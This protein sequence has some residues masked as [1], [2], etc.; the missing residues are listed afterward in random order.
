MPI[1]SGGQ[2]V[3]SAQGWSVQMDRTQWVLTH[4]YP[5]VLGD[6][7]K[8]SDWPQAFLPQPYAGDGVC[9]CSRGEN[10]SNSAG[11]CLPTCGNGV[12]DLGETSLNCPGDLRLFPGDA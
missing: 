9:E 7:G 1:A 6:K 2:T 3:F 4:W 5:F 11:D 8:P 10:A 12:A